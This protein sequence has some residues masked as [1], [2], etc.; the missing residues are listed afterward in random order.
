MNDLEYSNL[1][2]KLEDLYSTNAYKVV[3]VAFG[4]KQKNGT[5]LDKK[6]IRF[7][8]VQK[9]PAYTLPPEWV[10]PKTITIDG[11][12]YETDVYVAPEQVVAQPAYCNPPGTNSVP[13]VVTA[14]V[15]YNRALAVP[16]SGGV[17]FSAPPQTGFV[18]AGT[19]GGVVMDLFDYKIVGLTN[20]H[21]GSTPG[22]NI[23]EAVTPLIIASDTTWGATASAYQNIKQEQP[24]SWDNYPSVNYIS[25]LKRAY[26]LTTT[27]TN[28]I[29]A[30]VVNLNDSIVSTSSWYPLC[31]NFYTPPI[32]ATTTE[33]NSLSVNTPVFKSGRT[34]GPIGDTNACKLIISNTSTVLSVAYDFGNNLTF[35]NCLTITSPS[36]NT[37]VGSAGDSGSFVYALV[38]STNPL[39]SAWRIVGLFFAGATDGSSGYACRIDNVANLLGLSAYTGT[40]VSATP[41]LCSYV[42]LPYSTYSNTISTTIGGKTYWQV[43]RI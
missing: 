34:T 17:S 23:R 37:V 7:G 43:G 35:S 6:C 5:Y 9:V 21:V 36:T 8:V 38:N 10:I 18:N 16:L 22:G 29:D 27:G 39:T 3:Q 4:Q 31:A 30:C 42:T 26:P 24:S 13:P 20:S 32:F 28:Y 33:I 2:A 12:D 15:S 11:V 14:P 19:L 41:S 40:T 1:I 25:T